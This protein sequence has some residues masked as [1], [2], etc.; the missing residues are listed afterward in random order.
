MKFSLPKGLGLEICN[1]RSIDFIN[2]KSRKLID[3]GVANCKKIDNKHYEILKI[4]NGG[5]NLSFA[6]KA[7]WIIS[8]SKED[9]TV[10]FNYINPYAGHKEFVLPNDLVN[11]KSKQII[12]V[13]SE[14]NY[15]YKIK[16]SSSA[17]E[18]IKYILENL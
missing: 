1:Q 10:Y 6:Y 3:G 11:L 4:S 17:G 18:N 12:L 13:D 5:K 16:I 8:S 7:E 9:N 2:N 14:E 15:E